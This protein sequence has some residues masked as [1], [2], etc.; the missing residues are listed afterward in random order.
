MTSSPAASIHTANTHPAAQTPMMRQYLDAKGEHPDAIVLFRMGDF[1]ETFFEDAEVVARLL[2]LTLTSRNKKDAAPIPMAGVP[3]HALWSYV[4]RLLEAGHRVAICEQMEDPRS[5]KGLVHREVVRVI[6]PGVVLDEPALQSGDN[7]FLAALW[8][9]EEGAAPGL[10]WIDASTGERRGAI[11]SG[12]DRALDELGR[13][14]PREILV[15]R[16]DEGLAERIA[17]RLDGVV[18]SP[19]DLPEETTGDP[20]EHADAL[21][22]AYLAR[23]RMA[24][25]L[26]LKPLERQDLEGSLRLGVETVRNLEL[27]RTMA[28]GRRKGSLLGLMDRTRTAMG[29]RKIKQWLLYPLVDPAAIRARHDAVQAFFDDP[30]TRAT[31]RDD[32]AGVYDLE[33]LVTRTV[34]GTANPRDLI[35]LASSLERVGPIAERLRETGDPCLAELAAGLDPVPEAI[36]L[37]RSA[38]VDEPPAV[39][40]DGGV[41]REGFH[42][43]LDELIS[44]SRDGKAWFNRYAETLKEETG[45]ASLKVRFNNVFGYYIEVTKANLHHVPDTWLRKQTLANSE[46]YYTPEL[47]EREEKVLGAHDRRIA[48]EQELFEGVRGRVAA[49][50]ERIQGTA[51]RIA[52]L[53]VLSALAEL[54]QERGY[55]RPEVDD[56]LRVEIEQGRHPVI[57]SLVPAG[58][59]VPN[60]TTLDADD[61]QLLV[62]TGPN[63]A[64]KSTVMRQAALL[65][66]LA[67][68]GSFVP[69]AR[70]RIGV[71]DQVFTRVGASDNLARG[72][73]TFMVEMTESATILEQ[74]TRRS[75]VILD[76]IGRGTSTYDGVSIAWAVAEHLHDVIGARTLFATHYHEL[77][78]LEATRER[79]HNMT[80]AVKQWRD[81]IVFLRQLVPGGTNRSYGIQVAGLAGLPD[82]VV[83]RAR[84]V[85]HTLEDQALDRDSR[86]RLARHDERAR[87]DSWQLSLFAPAGGPGPAEERLGDIDPDDLTPRQALDLLYELKGLVDGDGG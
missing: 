2:E 81:D 40:K 66:I 23:T 19:V 61:E 20:L 33:R 50:G 5:A 1:Y 73:S 29:S 70:A 10:A 64:G 65:V 30:I 41:L 86:P 11:V 49:L 22:D 71:V 60:D 6:T 42:P 7:N 35:A 25:L 8:R 79:I 53:D 83:E 84:E 15:D 82:P 57:E 44:I 36:D 67:Q 76:E 48:L 32:L 51:D 9:P 85:L 58:E 39:L 43:E 12:V 3:Y 28:D 54:A 4:P 34:A 87:Q 75:L 47:K 80:I 62:I 27:L 63:M 21:V 24:D 18:L 59:F 69:A 78:E 38:L 31:T 37:V 16:R 46:R 17:A 14:E 45:I 74:A 56:G 77:T 52:A 68:M 13:I 55:V 26:P 72:Q